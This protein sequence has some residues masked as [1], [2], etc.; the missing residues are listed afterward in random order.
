MPLRRLS[1]E[2]SGILTLTRDIAAYSF[3]IPVGSPKASRSISP[4]G[5]L[6]VYLSISALLS[7]NEFATATWPEMCVR[8]TGFLGATAS[9]CWRLGNLFSDHMVWSHPPPVIHSPSLC[10][11][12]ASA[13][14][15]WSSSTDGTPVSGTARI[16]AA[17]PPRCTCAS[18]K[19]GMTNWPL[20][21]TVSTPS[22]PPPQSSRT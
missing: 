16:S 11:A 14:R 7:A 12:T 3:S 8:M 15:F 18:L 6:G 20:S 2:G 17:A 9:S 19:P 22:W 13:T 1:G 10:C 4:P 5:G 21:W